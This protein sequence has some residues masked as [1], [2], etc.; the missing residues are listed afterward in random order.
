MY[1]IDFV[2]SYN[3]YGDSYIDIDFNVTLFKHID[4]SFP[5]AYCETSFNDKIL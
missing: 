2:P 3:F 5:E 1:G 4:K